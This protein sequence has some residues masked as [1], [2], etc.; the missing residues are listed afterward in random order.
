M[1]LYYDNLKLT[2]IYFILPTRV[3]NYEVSGITLIVFLASSL[4]VSVQQESVST[5]V[6]YLPIYIP[7]TTSVDV[8]LT[9]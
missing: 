2:C 9:S 3:T 1:Y 6:H 8:T 5:H 4:H 7:T